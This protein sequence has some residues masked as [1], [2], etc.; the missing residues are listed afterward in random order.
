M[1]VKAVKCC[2]KLIL[3]DNYRISIHV[4]PQ[5]Y[6][7]TLYNARAGLYRRRDALNMSCFGNVTEK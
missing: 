5:V 3:K 2:I 1:N 7:Q 6:G 4:L